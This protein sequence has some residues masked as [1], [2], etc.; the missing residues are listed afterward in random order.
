[1]KGSRIQERNIE[2][3]LYCN[4]TIVLVSIEKKGGDGG[5]ERKVPL[6]RPTIHTKSK[7]PLSTP[8][9]MAMYFLCNLT[10]YCWD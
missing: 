2:R 6:Q 3:T 8:L 9:L 1:M 10:I 4:R 7:I 5:K